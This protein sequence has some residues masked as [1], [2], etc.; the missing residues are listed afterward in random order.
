MVLV[1]VKAMLTQSIARAVHAKYIALRIQIASTYKTK[2]V[3]TSTSRDQQGARGVARQRRFQDD[4]TQGVKPTNSHLVLLY[5]RVMRT[6]VEI[7][8]LQQGIHPPAVVPT[9]GRF[10]CGISDLPDLSK[11]SVRFR[12]NITPKVGP[13][14]RYPHHSKP[15]IS[16]ELL[17]PEIFGRH[18]FWR[19]KTSNARRRCT[20]GWT[21][22]SESVLVALKVAAQKNECEQLSESAAGC[23]MEAILLSGCSE[24]RDCARRIKEPKRIGKILLSPELST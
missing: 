24:F 2:N 10:R 21:H 22:L 20:S 4:N 12:F 7:C 6:R 15:C 13:D 11:L 23:V 3:S 1:V 14:W 16:N 18:P 19:C 9:C 8:F 5:R 17:D